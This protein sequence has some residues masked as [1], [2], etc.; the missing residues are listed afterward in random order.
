[1]TRSRMGS[2]SEAD[3]SQ[4]WSWYRQ[5]YS[6]AAIGRKLGRSLGPLDRE[7]RKH[8]GFSPPPRSR[9]ARVLS[10]CEREE[11][12]R[13]V[14]QQLS[15]GEIARRLGRC[16]STVSRELKRNGGQGAYRALAADQ[17]AWQQAS[18]PKRCLLKRHPRL[19]HAVSR[20]LLLQWSPQQISRWLPKAF[21]SDD[22]MRVSH[23]TIY[24]SLFI[25][26]RG[27]L[28][29]QLIEHLR[30]KRMGKLRRGKTASNKGHNAGQIVDAVSIRERPAEVEDRAVPGHWEGDLLAGSHHSHIATLVERRSRFVMLVKLPSRDSHTVVNALSRKIRRLPIELRQSLTWDRGKELAQHK[31][32][33]LATN[34]PIYF[35]DPHS[36][37]QR[38]TNEN[39][40][41][42]LRQYFPKG[43]DLS[44]HSQAHLNKI[45]QRLNQRPRETLG[46]ETP[47]DTLY[48][49][50]ATTL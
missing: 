50:V 46:F 5:G 2:L 14:S 8:G 4:L 40:N 10:L 49:S 11:I 29:K 47:A 6:A 33:T 7:L 42:L 25:Q 26:S 41:G 39:T 30:R 9:H 37:W 17:R 19:C 15:M 28:K 20:K 31:N 35:C 18:R 22:S 21:I 45:A 32:F 3:K 43:T 16:A 12:S 23:E 1:M 27:V 44:V 24:R 38:G 13:G 34:V 48:A 36:P